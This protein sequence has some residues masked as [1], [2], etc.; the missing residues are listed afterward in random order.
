MSS[1]DF[2]NFLPAGWSMQRN[3]SGDYDKYTLS[4][5][6]IEAATLI[7][8]D[9]IM[10]IKGFGLAGIQVYD[11]YKVKSFVPTDRGDRRIID[12]VVE[13]AKKN[14]KDFFRTMI[15]DVM[16]AD[17]NASE[18]HKAYMERHKASAT[19]KLTVVLQDFSKKWNLQ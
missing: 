16:R 18:D 10:F 14:Y 2:A 11:T 7:R 8:V 3:D 13:H 1:K 9:R 6:G 15:A 12:G 4:C 5:Q 17:Q 19:Q